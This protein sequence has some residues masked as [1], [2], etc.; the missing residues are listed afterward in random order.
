MN[1]ERLHAIARALRDDL[2][3]TGVLESLQQLRDALRN[4]VNVPQEASYQQQ[5]ATSLEAVTVAC[6]ASSSNEYPATWLEAL[7]DLR[8]EKLLGRHLG[9]AVRGIFA[10]NQITPSVAA[11]EVGNLY[12][13]L[14]AMSTALDQLVAGLEYFR[15]GAEE[16]KP[17]DAEV[18]VLI[19]RGVVN[20]HLEELGGEFQKLQKLL[21][22]FLELG[23]GSRPPVEV[24]TISSTDFGVFLD[25][26]PKA[27]AFVAVAVERIVALYKGL[28]E[29]RKLRQ[30]LEDQG[31]PAGNLAGI[32]DH[33]NSHM[34]KG[35]EVIGAEL[36]ADAPARLDEG[37]RNEL[38][39]ELRVSLNGIANRI[40][41]GFNIDVRG[42]A[43][44]T[45]DGEEMSDAGAAIETIRKA[46]P[47]LKFI[48]RSGR[49]ILSLPEQS[50]AEVPERSS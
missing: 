2:D 20:N 16:L 45:G 34:E 30:D 46:S 19:P 49:P 31:V 39:I 37:R 6:E 32:D 4:Q 12:E 47:N 28:L 18:G 7:D 48:N 41:A 15:I 36:V 35:I 42:A 5:V 27:A 17:G 21:G 50:E 33:A 24:V 38:E 25:V 44:E 22:P 10:R 14:E 26:A 13:E 29:I 8:V 9:A 43:E 1:A 3:G 40:D 11:A 23:T